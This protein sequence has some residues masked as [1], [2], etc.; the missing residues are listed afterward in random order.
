MHPAH[1]YSVLSSTEIEIDALVFLLLSH[2]TSITK[3]YAQTR[4]SGETRAQ[5]IRP[6]NNT[7]SLALTAKI[8]NKIKHVHE[9]RLSIDD[10]GG[11]FFRGD[12]RGYLS[13][14]VKLEAKS[15][16]SSSLDKKPVKQAPK[17]HSSKRPQPR[18]RLSRAA[19]LH[20]DYTSRG[21]RVGNT[22]E[23]GNKKNG[24]LFGTQT[25]R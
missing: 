20:I 11:L 1:M 22:K 17:K 19:C 4:S 21:E 5:E 6:G 24:R 23:G 12:Q 15:S 25:S 3:I 2:G 13:L 9:R 10:R 8:K 16:E 7:E 14:L 18:E